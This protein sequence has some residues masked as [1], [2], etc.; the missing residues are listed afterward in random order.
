M[1]NLK[2]IAALAKGALGPDELAELLAS[3]GWEIE[4]RAVDGADREHPF[5]LA[6]A[7]AVQPGSSMVAMVGKSK[8][9]Q[10]AHLI[11]IMEDAARALPASCTAK[12]TA[13]S[14]K[15]LDTGKAVA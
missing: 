7:A 13:N 2:S 11:I 5:R 4:M 14:K 9:G 10:R 6:A 3:L 15:T 1:L 8:T 12:V